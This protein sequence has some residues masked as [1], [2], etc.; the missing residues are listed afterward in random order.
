[1]IKARTAK[2]QIGQIVRYQTPSTHAIVPGIITAVNS[3]GT[4]SLASVA[5]GTWTSRTNV[6]YGNLD[7]GTNG[8]DNRFDYLPAF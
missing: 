2:F 8:N 1:M 6:V 4:V 3:D 5:A 7:G